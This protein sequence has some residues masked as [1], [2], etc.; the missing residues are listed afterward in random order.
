[1][2]SRVLIAD[3]NALIRRTIRTLIESQADVEVC[4]EAGNGVEAV[5][6][7][8][9]TSPDLTVMDFQMPMMDGLEATRKMKS[10]MPSMPVVMFVFDN[11]HQ[12]EMDCKQAGA[13]AV[14]SK[15]EAS[16]QL[17]EVISALA[18]PQ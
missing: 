17:P 3:D 14:L 18:H 11:S 9:E 8:L 5:H 7:A 2:S 1:M 10:L 12:L 13:D 4:A 15:V 6:R 16:S